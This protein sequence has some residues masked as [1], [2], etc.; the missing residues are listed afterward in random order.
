[1]KSCAFFSFLTFSLESRAK[2]WVLSN[3]STVYFNFLCK[4]LETL[5]ILI[6]RFTIRLT[7]QSIIP[8]HCILINVQK[9]CHEFLRPF[10]CM[11]CCFLFLLIYLNPIH[12]YYFMSFPVCIDFGSRS[13]GL[14]SRMS[15]RAGSAWHTK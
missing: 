9:N 10:I 6:H 14:W 15:R 7:F 12:S 13:L 11:Y 8:M 2:D 4:H 5:G 3:S 1:M